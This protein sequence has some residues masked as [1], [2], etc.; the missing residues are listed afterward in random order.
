MKKQLINNIY[1]WTINNLKLK[2]K[3]KIKKCVN[4]IF[5]DLNS[6]KYVVDT[7]N[8]TS[9]CVSDELNL[10]NTYC[11][12]VWVLEDKAIVKFQQ[13]NSMWFRIIPGLPNPIFEC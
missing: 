9:I 3:I 1:L 12:S 8:K 13:T 7:I 11:Y 2:R 10:G 4:F 5:N 6:K